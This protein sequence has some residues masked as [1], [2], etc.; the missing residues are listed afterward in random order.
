VSNVSGSRAPYDAIAGEFAA[1][2]AG[3]R[4]K[5]I[6]YL[7]RVLES[8]AAGSVVLDLG[9]GNGHPI[10]TYLAEQGH[11]IVGVDASGRMLA[12]ARERLPGHRWIHGKME[13]VNLDER[14][15]AIVCWDALFHVP[16][17]RWA[18]VLA[19]VHAWLRPGGRLMLSSGGVVEPDG[20]GFTDTMFGHEFYYDS[21]PPG[22]LLTLLA[23]LGFDIVL[24]EMCDLPDG[25]RNRGKWATI[26]ERRG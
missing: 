7:P 6:E 5:E 13:A 24:A 11:R 8:L 16:R 15:D 14:F 9:C 1:A 3:L 19:K 18:G 4:P 10:A 17:D 20:H 12:R 26:A 2:R 23:D 25:G 21:L 22:E